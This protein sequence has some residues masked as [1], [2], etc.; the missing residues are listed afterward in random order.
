MMD[1]NEL[2]HLIVGPVENG[3]SVTLCIQRY[4]LLKS[5]IIS[6]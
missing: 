6:T 3:F 1:A 2:G 4:L 5:E